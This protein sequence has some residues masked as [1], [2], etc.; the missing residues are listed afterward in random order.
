VIAFVSVASG[1]WPFIAFAGFL[2][3]ACGA[4]LAANVRR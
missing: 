3:A 4:A 2:I 1:K